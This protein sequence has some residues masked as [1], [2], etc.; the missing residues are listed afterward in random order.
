ML[1]CKFAEDIWTHHIENLTNSCTTRLVTFAVVWPQ[2]ATVHQIQHSKLS[3]GTFHVDTKSNTVVTSGLVNNAWFCAPGSSSSPKAPELE[4]NLCRQWLPDSKCPTTY[5]QLK[6]NNN[7]RK[8]VSSRASYFNMM[9][10]HLSCLNLPI[11][12]FIGTKLKGWMIK[13]TPTIS[14][15]MPSR[16][17]KANYIGLQQ[18][19]GQCMEQ[20]QSSLPMIPSPQPS[21]TKTAWDFT[22]LILFFDSP[23]GFWFCNWNVHPWTCGI[24]RLNT[25]IGI[26]HVMLINSNK[27]KRLVHGT[28]RWFD[29]TVSKSWLHNVS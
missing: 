7:L 18:Q 17:S 13:R 10:L 1:Q 9:L 14:Q 15:A 22:L 11:H 27:F 5:Q 4:A 21:S 24:K 23:L 25:C 16:C 8:R 6:Q 26:L 3:K 28:C 2:V 19:A 12:E 20:T 29:D